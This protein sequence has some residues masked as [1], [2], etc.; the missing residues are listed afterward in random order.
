MSI[1][2]SLTNRRAVMLSANNL[3]QCGMGGDMMCDTH[4]SGRA[5]V[6][7]S[8]L[9]SSFATATG[10]W[11]LA[12][13]SIPQ[14]PSN[15][16]RFSTFAIV[17]S[18]IVAAPSLA[19]WQINLPSSLRLCEKTTI[20]YEAPTTAY[21]YMYLP[22][23]S[24]KALDRLEGQ[25]KFVV[26]PTT[27]DPTTNVKGVKGTCSRSPLNCQFGDKVSFTLTSDDNGEHVEDKAGSIPIVKG[28]A[29]H[30]TVSA[31]VGYQFEKNQ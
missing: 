5:R 30:V 20:T 14:I 29:R 1:A 11:S 16:M 12:R 24:R 31:G 23:G 19:K 8:G 4:P 25:N 13:L 6:R 15:I 3:T 28:S 10:R 2:S 26:V 22:D 27:A 7:V 17:T 18:L 9:S 21:A